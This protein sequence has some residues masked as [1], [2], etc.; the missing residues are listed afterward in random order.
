MPKH[1]KQITCNNGEVFVFEDFFKEYF[2]KF[3]DFAMRFIED[4][5]ACEDIVQDTFISIWEG[6]VGSYDSILMFQAYIYKT[7]RNKALNYLKHSRIR[8]QYSQTYLKELESET[9]IME[10]VLEEE[11]HFVLYEAI[12][13]LTPQ[14]QQ[15][16]KLHLEGKSNKEI[17]EEMQISIVTVKSHKMVAYNKLREML[18]DVATLILFLL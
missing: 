17:A 18:K 10:S 9:F 3:Y 12:R 15:V 16:I 11:T 8:E 5:H 2:S 7:I 14:C 13:Q 6:N 1:S 4:R